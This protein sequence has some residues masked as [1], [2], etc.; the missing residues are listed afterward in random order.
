MGRLD[1]FKV[2]DGHQLLSA[3]TIAASQQK[4]AYIDYKS[5]QIRRSGPDHHPMVVGKLD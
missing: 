3:S 4:T 5:G 1:V 2:F